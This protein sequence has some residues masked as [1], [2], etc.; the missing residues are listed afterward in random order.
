M[1][2]DDAARVKSGGGGKG[3]A[4]NRDA[5]P[6]QR[7]LLLSQLYTILEG[8]PVGVFVAEAPGGRGL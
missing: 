4:M 6:R 8:L 1:V 5:E 2:G 3:M 7:E